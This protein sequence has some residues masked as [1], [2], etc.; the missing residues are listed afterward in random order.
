M[1]MNVLPSNMDGMKK[2]SN[3]NNKIKKRKEKNED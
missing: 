1:C 3:I 2:Q